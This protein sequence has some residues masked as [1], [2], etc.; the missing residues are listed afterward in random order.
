MHGPNFRPP[1][2]LEG[3]YVRLVPLSPGHRAA[4]AEAGADPEVGRYLL[5]GPGASLAEMD[6]LIALLLERQAAGTDLAFATLTASDGRPVG[7]TRFLHIDREDR[8]AEVGGTWLARRLWRT[9]CNTEAKYLL[10]RHAFEVEGAHRIYLQT[11]IRNE[12]S[13]RAI[14][15]I[16]ALQE[17]ILREDRRLADGSFRTSVYY[18]IL[19]REWP[20]VKRGLEEKLVR[21]WTGPV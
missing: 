8:N 15:R 21:P 5:N 9:P 1:L 10:L 6:R 18:G 19:D 14:E 13:R 17:A 2:T 20:A 12:R 16:G 3:R 11:D 7:M 4:L